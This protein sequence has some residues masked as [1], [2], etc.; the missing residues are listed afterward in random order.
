[1]LL[2]ITEAIKRPKPPAPYIPPPPVEIEGTF[3]ATSIKRDGLLTLRVECDN[4]T[5]WLAS[6]LT[7]NSLRAKITT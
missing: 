3:E 7:Q 4:E 2:N 1:M 5:D 6:Q